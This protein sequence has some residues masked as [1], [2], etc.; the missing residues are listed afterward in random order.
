[1][2]IVTNAS[3]QILV[4][5]AIRNFSY[6][7]IGVDSIVLSPD[8]RRSSENWT[9]ADFPKS[10]KDPCTSPE[11]MCDFH[12]DCDAGQD[13]SKCGDFRY[14]EGH[15]GWTD[16]SVGR[17]GW[18]LH[19]NSTSKELYLYVAE[20]AGRQ[21]TEAQT[22]TPLLGPSGPACTLLFDYALTGQPQHIGELS[23]RVLDALLGPLPKLWEFGGKTG[24]EAESWAQA[25]VHIGLRRT[26]FQL[27]FE[28]QLAQLHSS[29][30]IKVKNVMFEDCN[31]YYFPFSSTVVSCNFEEDLCGWQQDHSDNFD[32]M[33]LQGMD[34]TI[35]VGSSL[36]VDL[37]SPSLRGAFGRLL[38]FTVTPSVSDMCLSFFYK[39]YGP[40]TG[41]LNLKLLD[42]SG[43]E[44]LLW[45]RTGAHGN[46]FHEAHCPVPHQLLPFRL[47]FEVVRSGFDGRV[48]LDDV[49]LSEAPCSFLSRRCSFEGTR[50]DFR[51]S[52]E[53]LWR[54]T[55][56]LVS[57][58]NDHTLETPLGYYMMVNS[59][60]DV[61]RPGAV[62]TLSSPVHYGTARTECLQFWYHTGGD[63]PG[64]LTVY[65]KLV[66][67]A[68][69]VKIFSNS[70]NQG[71]EWRHGQGNISS[72][73]MDWQLEFEVVGAGGENTHVAIDDVHVSSQPCEPQ[74]S[75]CTLESGLCS[76]S[77]T[78]D[79]HKDRLDWELTSRE[80]ETHYP[81]PEAD[82][83][84]GH[85]QGHFLFLPSSER[86]APGQN[87]WLLSPHL[88]PT[89]GTCLKFWAYT[90]HSAVSELKVW[91]RSAGLN[92]ELL[93]IS[94]TQMSWRRF[95]INITSDQEYQ[96]VL[97]G[98]KGASGFIA[99]DD[100][101][102][103]VGLDCSG[104]HTDSENKR[105]D[106]GGIA[107]AV[108]V[109]LLLVVT[110]LA[111]LVYYLRTRR[112]PTAPPGGPAGFTNDSYDPD[113]TQDHIIVP[114][115]QNHP[116]AAGFNRFSAPDD[117]S[118]VEQD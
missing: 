4:M 36:V 111:L 99:L 86:T 66:N 50:C 77:N 65:M 19:H 102:F 53:V 108:T 61:L 21:T 98:V 25:E 94:H 63:R 2:E 101:Q 115:P 11:K 24:T 79:V 107:A 13:E 30:Q 100:I 14:V 33:L 9:L 69:R 88:P 48:A 82:H 42:G 92:T 64:S 56:G 37:W 12:F 18:L 114:P 16:S 60:S 10:P 97:E 75:V 54:H 105:P 5:A 35:G 3:F 31:E 8:C 116:M 41:T 117:L 89:R 52:G 90:P 55:Q 83:T 81:A 74:G 28:A 44:Q 34:H 38:S 43:Y 20:A 27:A 73:F 93:S 57:T 91:R 85:H 26:R 113:L 58:W 72:G 70:L 7:G 104:R 39:L 6:G 84:W 49:G 96:I 22:K 1:M 40:N 95:D 29:A 110:L 118:S 47:M 32:W 78:Q 17:Q 62:S 23:V 68:E 71:N 80:E 109:A 112:S 87:A 67:S 46:E 59:G 15:K 106:V 45:S 51:S 103:T 76:W